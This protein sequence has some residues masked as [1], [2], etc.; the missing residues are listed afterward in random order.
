VVQVKRSAGKLAQMGLI[1]D[2]VQEVIQI[3]ATDIEA[4][5]DFGAQIATDYLLG[6]A[7]I[8]G[9]VKTLLDIDRVLAGDALCDF[10]PS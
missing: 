8:K 2:G 1:V 9:S 10:N 7:K 4:P 6:M 5:P 3:A